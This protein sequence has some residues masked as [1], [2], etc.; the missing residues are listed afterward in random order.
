[1][2]AAVCAGC[3]AAQGWVPYIANYKEV[4]RVVAQNGNVVKSTE[5]RG[6]QMRSATGTQM[7]IR[8]KDGATVP[9]GRSSDA[10]SGKIFNI[11]YLEKRA[12]LVRSGPPRVAPHQSPT[13]KS[14]GTELIDGLLCHMFPVHEGGHSGPIVGTMWVSLNNSIEVRQE[15]N[16]ANAKGVKAHWA[17]SSAR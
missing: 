7:L 14:I 13:D 3:A 9:E 16:A 17:L 10:K 2:L 4:F 11:S 15:V 1:M 5:F 8:F 12:T 6:S